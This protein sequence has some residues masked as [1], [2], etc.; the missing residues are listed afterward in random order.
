MTDLIDLRIEHEAWNDLGMAAIATRSIGSVF[1]TL[2]INS[3]GY[4]ISVLACDDSMIKTLNAEFRDKEQPTNVLSWP[5]YDLA[6]ENAGGTPSAPPE[7]SDHSPELGDI[8][9]AYET[10]AAEA[11]AAGLS[12]SDHVTH[13]M[14]HGCLHLLGYDHE[15][16][17]DATVMETLE[18]A[19]LE[20]LNI[21]DPYR[22]SA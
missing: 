21:K 13:L 12:I 18:T 22:V 20:R 14:I 4:E 11:E 7:P 3:D 19:I 8:A 16:D 1:A 5:V 17:E 9:I 6:P 15:T 2:G 10:C